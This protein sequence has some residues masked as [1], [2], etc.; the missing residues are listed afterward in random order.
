MF[1]AT[2]QR[3]GLAA[4]GTRELRPKDPYL[5]MKQNNCIYGGAS[6]CKLSI[7]DMESNY[8]QF[9]KETN[10]LA[11][12]EHT[13]HDILRIKPMYGKTATFIQQ[14]QETA[15]GETLMHARPMQY[16]Y[17]SLIFILN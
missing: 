17:T 10:G 11:M 5:K 16:V 1:Y 14:F 3:D 13:V 7:A 4:C 12:Q 15:M 9:K 6:A 2:K 8:V